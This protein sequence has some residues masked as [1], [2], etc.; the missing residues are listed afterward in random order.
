MLGLLA[1]GLALLRTVDPAETDTLWVL[2]V[3]N[4]DGVA[5]E[6]TDHF[7]CEIVCMNRTGKSNKGQQRTDEKL[8]PVQ[9]KADVHPVTR[10]FG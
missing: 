1:V 3:Q 4:F 9:R 6:H 2:I 7:P 5:V 10:G 8:K